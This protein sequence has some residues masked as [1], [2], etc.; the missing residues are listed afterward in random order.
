MDPASAHRDWSVT[1]EL[2]GRTPGSGI[3]TVR[4]INGRLGALPA[5]DIHVDW[6]A[7]MEPIDVEIYALGLVADGAK[8]LLEAALEAVTAKAAESG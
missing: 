6:K 5:L 1:A 2:T 7:G 4:L 3:V 8:A